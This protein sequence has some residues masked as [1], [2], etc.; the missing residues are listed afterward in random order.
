MGSVGWVA[1]PQGEE[2]FVLSNGARGSISSLSWFAT[3][4]W[5][6]VTTW[7][8]EVQLLEV[9]QKGADVRAQHKASGPAAAPVQQAKQPLLCSACTEAKEGLSVA[10]GGCDGKLRVWNLQGVSMQEWGAH[11]KPIKAVIA[12]Q[13]QD[14]WYGDGF[15]TG[16]F[17]KTVALWITPG[18]PPEVKIPLMS[19]VFAMDGVAPYLLVAG[20]DRQQFLKIPQYSDFTW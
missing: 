2:R 15:V 8:G 20:S 6:A 11:E 16:S 12:L 18:A 17:D 3:R 1:V 7:D 19:K 13:Q 5:L 14:G 9:E 4:P 10:L